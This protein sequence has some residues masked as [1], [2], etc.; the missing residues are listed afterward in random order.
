MKR[1]VLLY[2]GVI[3]TVLFFVFIGIGIALKNRE[4]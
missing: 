2:I 4:K 1:E 3:S